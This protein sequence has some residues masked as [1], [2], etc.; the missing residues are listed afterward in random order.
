MLQ[1]LFVFHILACMLLIGLVLIQHGKGAD[2]GVAFGSSAKSFFGAQGATSTL[3]KITTVTA[4]VFFCTSF[5]IGII[6]KEYSKP[7]SFIEKSL[8]AEK[9]TPSKKK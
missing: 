1:L 8:N 5:F 9:Q 4:I 3:V 7:Q 2:M 6:N